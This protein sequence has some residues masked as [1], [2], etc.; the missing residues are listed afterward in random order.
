MKCCSLKSL[1][2]TSNIYVPSRAHGRYNQICNMNVNCR[3]FLWSSVSINY[4]ASPKVLEV[5]FGTGFLNKTYTDNLIFFST[6]HHHHHH[7]HVCHC[8]WL[9]IVGMEEIPSLNM[10][11]QRLKVAILRL[12]LPCSGP[13]THLGEILSTGKSHGKKPDRFYSLK[14]KSLKTKGNREKEEEEMSRLVRNS[15]VNVKRGRSQNVFSS[16]GS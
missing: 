4:V 2:A 9:C 8:C 3:R 10:P 7:H 13:V 11:V 12:G 14:M 1:Q 16:E 5:V 15:T 6:N